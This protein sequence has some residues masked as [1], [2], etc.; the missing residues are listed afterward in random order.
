MPNILK[1]FSNCLI[2]SIYFKINAKSLDNGLLDFV[3]LQP[4]KDLEGN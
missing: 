2:F 3:P 1:S 4:D